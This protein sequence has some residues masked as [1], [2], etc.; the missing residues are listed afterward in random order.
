VFEVALHSAFALYGHPKAISGWGV[1]FGNLTLQLPRGL[2][3]TSIVLRKLALAG[4]AVA[5]LSMAA[6]S[7]PAAT[8]DTN[9]T[10]DT[11]AAPDNSMS[12]MT[13][14]T[15]MTNNTAS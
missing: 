7:K 9:T 5:A 3:M 15:T 12:N 10:T 1:Q 8:N 13:T 4:A 11:T 14:D 2:G 6:C